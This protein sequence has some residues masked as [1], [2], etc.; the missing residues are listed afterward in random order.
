MAERELNGA[1]PLLCKPDWPKAQARWTAFWDRAATDR[2][3]L[4]VRAPSGRRPAP[5][6]K[7]ENWQA[8]YLDPDYVERQWLAAVEATYFG[9]DA[10]PCPGFLMGGYALGCNEHVKFVENTVWHPHMIDRMV[11]PV[12]W[13]PGP[14]DPWRAKLDR[15]IERLRAASRGNFLVG[16]TGQIPL[17]DLLMLLRG[18]DDF[19]IELIERTDDCVRCLEHA[20]PLWVENKE[21]IREVTDRGQFGHVYGYPGLWARDYVLAT[22]SD[23]CCMI[24]PA[25][26][27]RWVLREFDLLSERYPVMWYHLDGPGAIKHLDALLGRP[28]IRCI[29]YVPGSGQPPNGPAWMDLYRRVQ[30]A[31]RCLEIAAPPEHAEF[32]IR[33]LKP[34]GLLLRTYA[35]TPQQADELADRA[36]RWAGTH[37]GDSPP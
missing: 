5:Q 20:L 11:P 6:P 31:G 1:G 23:M 33:R 7:P 12:N 29:Q 21:H 28:Y 2:P 32:L 10:V 27:E 34:Q 25:L 19:L 3:L 15:V 13:H 22:Q 36:R 30:A 17:N 35:P 18:T 9:V 14:A 24:S 4:D 16:Y 8:K 37:A 26:F